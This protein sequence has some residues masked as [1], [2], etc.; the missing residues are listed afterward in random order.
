MNTRAKSHWRL[1]CLH[2][3]GRTAP[4]FELTLETKL[5]EVWKPEGF[6]DTQQKVRKSG[7]IF[8]RPLE[9]IIYEGICLSAKRVRV[10]GDTS[11]LLWCCSPHF[12]LL[13]M[14]VWRVSE[15]EG[16]GSLR[17]LVKR[18]LKGWAEGE[19]ALSWLCVCVYKYAYIHT[20]ICMKIC[21]QSHWLSVNNY[22]QKPSIYCN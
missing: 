12:V 22:S 15:D 19:S 13:F 14:H 5:L 7:A 18:L 2:C 21:T 9:N 10:V 4:N 11:V 17:L 1:A 3:W 20:Y 6:Q 16:W 8:P